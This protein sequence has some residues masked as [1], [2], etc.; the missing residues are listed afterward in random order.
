MQFCRVNHGMGS[1]TVLK[2]LS[3]NTAGYWNHKW[4]TIK[5]GQEKKTGIKKETVTTSRNA[6]ALAGFITDWGEIANVPVV[7][8]IKT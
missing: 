8:Q 7:W 2:T 5:L 4:N 6:A 1:R 3:L